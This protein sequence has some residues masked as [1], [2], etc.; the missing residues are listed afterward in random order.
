MTAQIA[1]ASAG[2]PST[3]TTDA[4]DLSADFRATFRNS[5]G[6]VSVITAGTGLRPVGFTATSLTSVS[7]D[8]PI[9]SLNIS[10]TASSWPTVSRARH[11]AAHLLA[12]EHQQTAQIFATSGIDR[13]AAVGDWATGPH[14]IP[15][16]TRSL[17]RLVLEVHSCTHIG[18]SAVLLA[19]VQ[20][21]ER[22]E[23]QPLIYHAGDYRHL[24]G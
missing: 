1:A 16:L 12:A 22:S 11:L 9:V 24:P 8:P 5:V 14:G 2:A 13:F 15:V 18:D 23:G 21:I 7:L 17:A 4:A 19:Q 3:R 20:Q 6:T 10:R